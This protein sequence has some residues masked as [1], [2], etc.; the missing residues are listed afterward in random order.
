MIHD[1]DLDQP[2]RRPRVLVQTAA[3]VSGAAYYYK[4]DE[5]MQVNGKPAKQMGVCIHPSF[6][7]WFAIRGVVIFKDITSDSLIQK[8]PKDVLPGYEN[9]KNLLIQFSNW[10]DG[11]YR[12]VIP[13]TKRYSNLQK[14]YFALKPSERKTLIKELVTLEN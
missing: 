9:K 11:R 3:H 4:P 5:H 13:V 6:G 12:D 1:F 10:S 2:H 14:K 8:I 7:G